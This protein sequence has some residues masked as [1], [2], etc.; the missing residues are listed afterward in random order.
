[1]VDKV[2]MKQGFPCQFHSTGAPL[3]GKTKKKLIT[4]I[5]GLQNKPQGCSASV[6][7]AAGPF[8]TKSREVAVVVREWLR[9]QELNFHRDGI[10]KQI[11]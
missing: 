7:S 2:A 1:M 3:H 8:T 11:F 6:A 5:I 4:F 9:I 10:F